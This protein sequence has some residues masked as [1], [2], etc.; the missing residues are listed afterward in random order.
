MHRFLFSLAI[1]A[2]ALACPA[3]AEDLR[4]AIQAAIDTHPRLQQERANLRAAREGIPLA[5]APYRPQVSF[6]A[7][8]ARSDREAELSDGQIINDEA[9]PATYT[10][11]ARQTIWS[12]GRRDIAA[13]RSILVVRAQEV[14]YA[15]VEQTIVFDVATAYADLL[16]SDETLRIESEALRAFDRQVGAARTQLERGTATRTDLAQAE[17]RLAEARARLATARANLTVAHAQFERMTGYPAGGLEWEA[18]ELPW[19]DLLDVTEL[20]L[21]FNTDLASARLNA[22][23]ARLDLMA[24]NRRNSPTVTLGLQHSESDNVSPA[25][26]SDD[27]TQVNLTLT[28]PLLTGG[29]NGA[30]RRQA[31][32]SRSA[33]RFAVRDVEEDVRLQ[34]TQVWA[35]IE[36]ASYVLDAQRERVIASELALEGVER[37]RTAGLWTL[38]DVLN[39]TDQLLRARLSLAEGQR[40]LRLGRVRLALMTGALEY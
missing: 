25:V 29:E 27:D 8:T 36:A 6:Q 20:A 7:T 1:L 10:L 31:A 34:A 40:E 28:V 38:V 19:T 39:A 32:A 33:S 12:G 26:I 2:L 15:A 23:I 11:D 21:E 14:Q 22:E 24:A 37:G 17:A 18:I 9:S 16:L 3:Q 5:L 4:D 30:H 35:Q 13:R